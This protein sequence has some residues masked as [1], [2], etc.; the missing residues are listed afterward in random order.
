MT[1]NKTASAERP[2]AASAGPTI[3]EN[4]TLTRRRLEPNAPARPVAKY[5]GEDAPKAG[6]V[7]QFTLKNGVTYRGTVADATQA[8]G[9]VLAEF[10]GDLQPEPKPK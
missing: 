9:E 5:K 6:D 7:L 8:D 1:T 2:I 10:Q 4:V 3:V